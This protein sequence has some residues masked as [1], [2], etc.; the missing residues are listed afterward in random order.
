MDLHC[1]VETGYRTSSFIGKKSKEIKH[2]V[3]SLDGLLQKYDTLFDNKFGTMKG[4]Q[5]KLTI[6]PDAKPKFC[7]A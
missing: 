3:T 7:R 4:V 5:A 1:S 6:K 2:V